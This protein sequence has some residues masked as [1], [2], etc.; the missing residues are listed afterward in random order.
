MV[1]ERKLVGYER[2][3]RRM[4][5]ILSPL[6]FASHSTYLFSFINFYL[7]T[8]PPSPIDFPSLESGQEATLGHV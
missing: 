6:F 2:E 8:Q 4:D 7:I 5:N 3:P 1:G